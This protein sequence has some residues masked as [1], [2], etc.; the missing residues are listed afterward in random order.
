M[1]RAE[2]PPPAPCPDSKVT[3]VSRWATE[4]LSQPPHTGHLGESLS[5]VAL[6]S[7][8]R[9]FCKQSRFSDSS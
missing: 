4:A 6:G 1:V 8:H 5:K 7:L 3:P 2:E 9:H